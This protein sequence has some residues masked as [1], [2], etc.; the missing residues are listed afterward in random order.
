MSRYIIQSSE[1]LNELE[2]LKDAA[3]DKKTHLYRIWIMGLESD[4][5]QSR[6]MVS[7][8]RIRQNSKVATEHKGHDGWN[9]KAVH[10]FLQLLLCLLQGAIQFNSLIQQLYW[11]EEK[12]LRLSVAFKLPTKAGFTSS[13][14]LKGQ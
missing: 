1:L 11:K 13:L 12:V 4:L 10:Y 3:T 14:L 2:S 9:K 7:K 8:A 6:H 5:L